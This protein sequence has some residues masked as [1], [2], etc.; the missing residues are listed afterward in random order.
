M[1]LKAKSDYKSFS[2][3]VNTLRSQSFI[4]QRPK[5][6]NI[7]QRRLEKKRKFSQNFDQ[8]KVGANSETSSIS[9]LELSIKKPGSVLNTKESPV[10]N[11]RS[12]IYDLDYGSIPT[13]NSEYLEK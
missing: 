10:Q 3:K 8:S 5:G 9:S 2:L 1:M 7:F 11:L 13:T 6:Q 12:G 4:A